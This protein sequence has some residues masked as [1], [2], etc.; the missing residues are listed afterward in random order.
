MR[1]HIVCASSTRRIVGDA[2]A[3]A[4]LQ[5]SQRRCLSQSTDNGRATTGAAAAPRFLKLSTSEDGITT[6]QLARPSVNSL[7]VAFLG[8]INACLQHLST[9]PATKAVIL[10]SAMPGVFSAGLDLSEV[11]N[12]E[13]EQLEALWYALQDMWIHLN[14]FPLPIVAAV[15]GSAPGGGCVMAMGCDYR[16]MARGPK[17]TAGNKLYRLGLN[18]VQVGLGLPA[19]I[20]AAYEALMG[21]RVAERLALMGDLLTADEAVQV[22]LIDEVAADEDAAMAA[23]HRQIQRFVTVPQKARAMARATMRRKALQPLATEQ[24]RAMDTARFVDSIM[25]PT[26]QKNVGEYLEHLKSRSRR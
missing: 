10:S 5:P 12:P 7:S 14:S 4:P 25:D 8:E 23:A 20:A 11:Y 13:R 24:D 16:V 18:E 15:T 6:L 19:W 2:V 17:G 9:A 3:C 22:Q 26:V 21:Q 1:R